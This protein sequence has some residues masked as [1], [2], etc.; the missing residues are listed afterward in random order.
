MAT[1]EQA[2]ERLEAIVEEMNG[3]EI[4]LERALALFEEGIVHLRTASD[5]LR[6]A[7][8]AVQVLVEQADGIL[9][10]RELGA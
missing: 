3:E 10:A 9:E 4:P 6:R 2:L 7:E 1:F 8:S 5:E